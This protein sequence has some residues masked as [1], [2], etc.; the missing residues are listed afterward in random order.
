MTPIDFATL[1][2]KMDLDD[3]EEIGEDLA[4]IAKGIQW[5]ALEIRKLRAEV[6]LWREYAEL[7]GA[8]L[9]EIIPYTA[10]H[11]WRSNRHE[12]G[13][14]LRGLLGIKGDGE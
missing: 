8:E 14:R 1:L 12:E 11:G 2:T 3:L 5:A 7:L 9:I 13:K 4:A 10:N 6:A